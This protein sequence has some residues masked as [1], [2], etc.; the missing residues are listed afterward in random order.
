MTTAG[1]SLR[2]ETG[3][4]F[5]VSPDPRPRAVETCDACGARSLCTRKPC[6]ECGLLYSTCEVCRRE[7]GGRALDWQVQGHQKR[8]HGP[9]PR[10]RVEVQTW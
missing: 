3:R 2:Y 8:A 4:T 9:P 7:T 1:M 10:K 6:P 5:E